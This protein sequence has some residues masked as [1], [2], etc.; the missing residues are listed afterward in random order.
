[1]WEKEKHNS[2]HAA[3]SEISF[4]LTL[5]F[6]CVEEETSL[7][8]NCTNVTFLV[9]KVPGCLAM[10]LLLFQCRGFPSS[11]PIKEQCFPLLTFSGVCR[12][13]HVSCLLRSQLAAGL[14]FTLL[15]CWWFLTSANMPD[16][17]A[18]SS[19]LKIDIGL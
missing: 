13:C 16:G 11:H 4:P 3:S 19:V 2:V 1:M 7:T 5:L 6:N 15:L 9:L 14:R 18:Q 12:A 17:L 10:A 8:V